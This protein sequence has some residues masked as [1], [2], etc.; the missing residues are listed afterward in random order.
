MRELTPNTFN[1]EVLYNGNVSIVAFYAPWCGYCQQLA[2]ELK[3]AAK[4]LNGIAR[5]SAVNCDSP[6][7]QPLCQ[8]F[9]VKGFPT[10]K[11]FQPAKL[12]DVDFKDAVAGKPL[13]RRKPKLFAYNGP[14]TA[15]ALTEF[16]IQ[17]LRNYAA[18]LSTDDSLKWLAPNL[19]PRV[20]M[21][22]GKKYKSKSV[23]PLFKIL[24][25]EYFGKVRFAAIPRRVDGAWN[26]L[27][28]TA[29]EESQLVYMSDD[30]EPVI[31]KGN[32]KKK[33]IKAFI[34]EQYQLEMHRRKRSG[35]DADRENAA[36]GMEYVVEDAQTEEL[37][38]VAKRNEMLEKERQK[39]RQ[40]RKEAFVRAGIEFD[41][42]ELDAERTDTTQ[43][44]TETSSHQ[45][46]SA[47]DEEGEEEELTGFEAD[48]D[49]DDNKNEDAKD[50]GQPEEDDDLEEAELDEAIVN[51]K[52][53]EMVE[54]GPEALEKYLNSLK[55]S[56]RAEPVA[57]TATEKEG[58]KTAPTATG[59]TDT[60]S[61]TPIREL[62]LKSYDMFVSNCLCRG[63]H[64]AIAIAR[65]DTLS[66]DL[67]SLAK[68]VK[69]VPNKVK[70]YTLFEFFIAGEDPTIDGFLESIGATQAPGML[71]YDSARQKVDV[72]Q[73][74]YMPQHISEFLIS[75]YKKKRVAD[76]PIPSEYLYWVT[77][78]EVEAKLKEQDSA[79]GDDFIKDEL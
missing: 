60:S 41:E 3:Q 7:N 22:P 1:K 43:T 24:S 18:T 30:R 62:G 25:R 71:F 55:E 59:A 79:E 72:M 51:V 49:M 47:K 78:A 23:S 5:V 67:S 20:I 35:K 34:D 14:R 44:K 16:S 52:P 54:E 48:A 66:S 19:V 2:P 58:T 6:K 46:N 57:V 42:A 69:T 77:Q 12:T 68:V 61:A 10:I 38:H 65:N 36:N 26:L 64:C 9:N 53:D 4:S 13:P 76:T 73:S 15:S 50:E 56:Q 63:Y 32:M 74:D 8:R 21:L 17:K 29:P 40:A 75:L 39:A 11:V 27:G 28:L 33:P 31:Y 70:H 37:E 45:S